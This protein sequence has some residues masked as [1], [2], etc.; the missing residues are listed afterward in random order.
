MAKSAP[1]AATSVAH[2]PIIRE[3]TAM[4]SRSPPRD[5]SDRFGYF[6][7]KYTA[8]LRPSAAAVP[9][10]TNVIES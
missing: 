5:G 9:N 8:R 3:A 6:P 7:Q 10:L 1:L 2:P 4:F